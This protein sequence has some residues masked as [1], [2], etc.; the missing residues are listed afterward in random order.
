[1]K[2]ER[3]KRINASFST[4]GT[5]S[6]TQKL[7]GIKRKSASS[8]GVQIKKAAPENSSLQDEEPAVEKPNISNPISLIAQEYGNSSDDS[9]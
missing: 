6:A 1:M 4:A 8:L 7:L 3:D 2:A 5:S 9:D